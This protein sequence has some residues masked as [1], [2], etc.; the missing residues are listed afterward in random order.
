M[1]NIDGVM[2]SRALRE[3]RPKIRILAMSG[4]ADHGT[5]GTDNSKIQ[6]LAHGFIVKPFKP[7]ALLGAVHLALHPTEKT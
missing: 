4:T 7:E 5:D 6:A 1:P 3:L 2:L